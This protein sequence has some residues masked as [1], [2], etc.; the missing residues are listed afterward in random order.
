MLI[1]KTL[2]HRTIH[3][4]PAPSITLGL[5]VFVHEVMAAMTTD[6]CFNVYFWPL[7]SN[8]ALA[9]SLSLLMLNPLKPICKEKEI[10]IESLKIIIKRWHVTELRPHLGGGGGTPRRKLS[11]AGSIRWIDVVYI[12]VYYICV[13]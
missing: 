6:P 8:S 11:R 10:L 2:T 1:M 13:N 9:F 12:N 3:H 7:N 4:S 5:L